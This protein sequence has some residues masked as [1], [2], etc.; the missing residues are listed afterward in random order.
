[1][2]INSNREGGSAD[3][4]LGFKKNWRDLKRP[5]MGFAKL[6]VTGVVY[7]LYV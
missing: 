5:L 2:Y 3:G 7:V 4:I 1:M 6:S